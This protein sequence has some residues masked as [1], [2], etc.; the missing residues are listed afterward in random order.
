[1]P[2]STQPAPSASVRATAPV[3]PLLPVERDTIPKI[4]LG[5]VDRFGRV[6]ALRFHRDGRWE[7]MSHPEAERRVAAIAAWLGSIGVRA[8][9]RVAIVSETRAEWALADYAILGMGAV[10][11]PVYPTL[12]PNQVLY[13]LRDS[14]ARAVFVSTA[15][16]AAK[17]AGLRGELPELAEAVAFDD[18]G[19]ATGT[20]RLEDVIE[21]GQR[22]IE[23]G[24][25]EDF[26]AM[27]ARAKP[28]DLATLIYTS[29]TTGLP[30][31][32]M[33][34]HFNIASNVASCAQQNAM[35]V[36]AD[37]VALSFL[38][39]SHIFERMA[40][41]WFWDAGICIAYARSM[42]TVIDD[43]AE[44]RPTVAVSVP[45][46]FEKVY[47]KVTGAPGLKGRIARW[48]VAVGAP[49]VDGRMA[50]REPG[51]T[52]AV[53]YRLADRLVFSKLRAR[54]G[55]RMRI[56][57]S[58]SAPL[59]ADIARF[60]F[61]A[62]VPVYEGYGLTETSPVLTVNVPE[63]TRLGTVGPAIPGVELR[64]GEGGEILARGPN[65]MRGYWND[66][67]ATADAIDP[68]G[69]FHTGDV[70]EIDADGYLR[71]TDRIKNLIVTAGGKNVAPQPMENVAAL[72]PF[73]AQVVMI[74]D[75]RAFP[76]MLVVP[77]FENLRPWA[78]SQGIADDDIQALVRDPRVRALLERETVG[79]LDGFARYELPKK[80]TI[81]AEEFSIA[82]GLLTPTLKVKRRA[83]EER[84]RSE[85]E[86]MYAG[87]ASSDD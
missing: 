19:G 48:A 67:Q 42:E 53:R 69:W 70:G 2:V 66:P 29:G 80:I 49:V 57:R 26:R 75:R 6:E 11:V 78:K 82:D 43:F 7:T 24:R 54:L 12:P 32:V 87:N 5:A 41:Y 17:V 51:G 3:T 46:M 28:D 59:A 27:A 63:A 9:D 4:F 10:G 72:S 40:D 76:S 8:G 25:A 74:G 38:P 85:I 77:D 79:R 35:E 20:L 84:Y 37:D 30:K 21:A 83:V 45:R 39:L 62:G 13:I 14:G 68:D 16:Q 47:A 50:G 34:T 22:E 73:V 31:G 15:E 65:V 56:F 61:A 58:G 86:E 60:F 36:R 64:I 55:G 52:L 71:I 33:L 44:V 18:A 1:M 23:A 81:I